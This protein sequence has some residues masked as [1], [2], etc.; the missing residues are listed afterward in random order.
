MKISSIALMLIACFGLLTTGTYAQTSTQL[1]NSENNSQTSVVVG[2]PEYDQM[3]LAGTLPANLITNLTKPDPNAISLIPNLGSGSVDRAGACDCYVDPDGS[4]TNAIGPNDDGSTALLPIP[5]NFCF[6]GNQITGV[7]VNN[8]GNISFGAPFGT[9][10]SASFP[11]P[12]FDMVAPFWGDIDTRLV[13]GQPN[14]EVWYKITPTAMY[15]NWVDCGY[16]SMHDDKKVTFQLII[17]DGT[18]PAVPGGNNIAFCYKNMDWTT[19]DASQGVN[20][21]GG[22]PATVGINQGNGVDYLQ[23]GRFDAVGNAYDGSYGNNDGVDWLDFQTFFFNVCSS[24]NIPPIANGVAPC[25]TF[26]ICALNDTLI[27][28]TY[29][30]SPEI[31]QTTSVVITGGGM[32]GLSVISNVPGNTATA[33]AQIVGLSSNIGYNTVTFVAT[34]DGVP[35]GVTTVNVVILVDTTGNSNF[36][37]SITG[38]NYICPGGSVILDAGGPFDTYF[39]NNLSN[40]QTT[41][42][43]DSGAYYATVSLNGCYKTA[44]HYVALAP[45]ANPIILGDSCAFAGNVGQLELQDS[46]VYTSI[47]WST[48]DTTAIIDI[49]AA[50]TYTVTLS[51]TFGCS[52]TTNFAVSDGPTIMADTIICDAFIVALTATSASGGTW[53]L[54]QNS[55]GLPVSIDDPNANSTFMTVDT[56]G[57][58]SGYGLYS[59]IY[60]DNVCQVSDTV[61]ITLIAPIWPFAIGDTCLDFG[62]TG[63]LSIPDSLGFDNILWGD[64]ET[65]F[66]IVTSGPDTYTF[67]ATD[68]VGCTN[69]NSFVVNAFP[70][71]MD[72]ILICDAFIFDL[73]ADSYG[74]GGTWSVVTNPSGLPLTISNPG[75][76]ATIGEVDVSGVADSLAYGVYVFQFTPNAC[77]GPLT[78]E[79]ELFPP[80]WPFALGDVCLTVGVPGS[81]YIADPLAFDSIVWSTGDT[82]FDIT[83]NAPGTYTFTATDTNGCANTN[84]IIVNN[85]STIMDDIVICDA[86]IFDLTANS[87]GNGGTWSVLVNPSGLPLTISNPGNDGTIAEVDVSGVIDSLAY[88]EY[89]FQFTPNVCGGPLTV[90][91]NLFP[92]HW[93]FAQGD[94]C[95]VVGATGVLNINNPGAFDNI[96]WGDGETTFSITT[97]GPGVYSWIAVDTNACVN[98]NTFTVYEAP[99]IGPDDFECDFYYADL[100][101]TAAGGGF[102][103]LVGGPAGAAFDDFSQENTGVTADL[104]GL[105]TFSWTDY[106]CHITQSV[107]ILFNIPP[108]GWLVDYTMCDGDTASL[109][110]LTG[111][112]NAVYDW[113]TGETTQEISTTIGGIYTVQAT[114]DCGSIEMSSEIT[115]NECDVVIPNVFSPNSDGYND[116]WVIWGLEEHPGTSV[117]IFDRWGKE[118]YSSSDY[119]NNWD[120]DNQHGGVY[121]YIVKTQRGGDY[122]GNIQLIR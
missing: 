113:S 9:F 52:G 1:G 17:T 99:T 121:Y 87:Y 82:L 32:T 80:H 30:L 85:I 24:T 102:W 64:G 72:D 112:V 66:E 116:M 5:F 28:P 15:V 47:S 103:S 74:D 68:T 41:T 104:L 107:D 25:D 50:G 96:V 7:Y 43:L 67:T 18:D 122:S 46:L 118:V 11:D 37:P 75:N 33:V 109:N 51:D 93:P 63:V 65:T 73:T 42:G 34:D 91:V 59:F 12:N 54:D 94:T 44:F 76:D 26:T 106:I 69:S 110:A 13:G 115:V 48:G 21:F 84:D 23:I 36:N 8:N 70:T 53:G 92:P 101:A 29:W 57:G 31:G 3:K 71:I 2:S 4:Y 100:T 60:T 105:H 6:Y 78:V 81:L 55:T 117:I 35:A 114:N 95:L 89:E 40:Q 39:W 10:S 86:F 27:L 77:G 108:S 56:A 14:G 38:P 61:V 20:G 49:S 111:G 98:T 16:F 58:A 83:I 120:G 97:A 19:G 79:V 119:A 88:G 90:T 45:S 22:T 62:T